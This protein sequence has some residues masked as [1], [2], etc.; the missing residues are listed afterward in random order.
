MCQK[1]VEVTWI[2]LFAFLYFH[3]CGKRI[4]VSAY[5]IEERAGLVRAEEQSSEADFTHQLMAL[6]YYYTRNF[7]WKHTRF[8]LVSISVWSIRGN[9]LR[10]SNASTPYSMRTRL[11][12]FPFKAQCKHQIHFSTSSPGIYLHFA[13]KSTNSFC[14]LA[15]SNHRA[16]RAHFYLEICLFCT[17][18]CHVADFITLQIGQSPSY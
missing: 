13:N 4:S 7:L 16:E 11:V 17:K 5:R 12:A 1:I 18:F 15:T 9:V 10:T 2:G 6:R 3:I 8:R 14:S